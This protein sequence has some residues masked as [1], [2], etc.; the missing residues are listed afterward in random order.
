[1]GKKQDGNTAR[2]FF[3]I[4]CYVGTALLLLYLFSEQGESS[5]TCLP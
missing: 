2:L 5:L 1:M 4:A 3:V